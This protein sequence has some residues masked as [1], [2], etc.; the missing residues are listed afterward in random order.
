MPVLVFN[1]FAHSQN[2]VSRFSMDFFRRVR[3][4][5]LLHQS[6]NPFESVYHT[7]AGPSQ[8]VVVC[9]AKESVSLDSRLVAE[10]FDNCP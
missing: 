7:A 10:L 6:T 5:L 1:G 3:G 9:T 4:V 2:Y 8:V